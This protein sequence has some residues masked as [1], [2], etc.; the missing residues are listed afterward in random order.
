MENNPN[1]Q[2]QG[3]QQSAQ[4]PA[5]PTKFCKN[6]GGKIAEKAV[7]CPL[8]GCQVEEMKSTNTAAQPQQ[9]VINNSNSNV[10]QNNIGMVGGRMKN[11]WVAVLLCFFLGYLG[12][13]RFYEGK[14]GSGILYLLTFGVFGIGWFIDFLI[15]LCKPNPYYV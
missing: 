3:T 11:K 6:C 4:N 1:M 14:V 5:V 13:H 7:I 2:A 15:L 8:C 12:A 10:N 9:I